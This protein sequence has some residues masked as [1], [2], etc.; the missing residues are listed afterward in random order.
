VNKTSTVFL[1]PGR[2]TD[3][4]LDVPNGDCLPDDG[5]ERLAE[6][7]DGDTDGGR[8]DRVP[9]MRLTPPKPRGD[10][11]CSAA[12]DAA[13]GT[14]AR[15][16]LSPYFEMSTPQGSPAG[17]RAATP[18]GEASSAAA[19]AAAAATGT[20]NAGV[21]GAAAHASEPVLATSIAESP[22]E[23]PSSKLEF[24]WQFE[25]LNSLPRDRAIALVDYLRSTEQQRSQACALLKQ[26]QQTNGELERRLRGLPGGH[27]SGGSSCFRRV[28]CCCLVICL[29]PALVLVAAT[30]AAAA[31]GILPPSVE[32]LPGTWSQV[33]EEMGDVLSSRG[34]SKL[35]P[36]IGG[37]DS[38][39]SD[40]CARKPII[41]TTVREMTLRETTTRE[42]TR[43]EFD[44]LKSENQALKTE[45]EAMSAQL[46]RLHMDIDDAV[47][48]GQDMVC[49]KV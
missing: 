21:H 22:P 2:A 18:R 43:E 26:V 30:S 7:E 13:A 14:H 8:R 3:N 33:Y 42:Y 15:T 24:E 35:V 29:L 5:D 38:A 28:R 16:R 37:F 1:R 40:N 36:A 47:H 27:Y 17:S 25:I 45:H 49:W 23:D 4:A 48:R 20:V 41:E 12:A 10:A 34:L 44:K 32:G 9:T 11:Q 46:T 19:G 39:S 31:M 6:D